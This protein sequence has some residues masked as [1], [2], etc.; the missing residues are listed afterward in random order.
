[1]PT[2][3]PEWMPVK[4]AATHAGLSERTLWRLIRSGAVVT[5]LSDGTPKKRLVRCDSLPSDSVNGSD[6][7]GALAHTDTRPANRA[8]KPVTLSD[9]T[10]LATVLADVGAAN[11]AMREELA[12]LRENAERQASE[13]AAIRREA[14]EREERLLSEL[15]AVR[16]ALAPSPAPV[17]ATPQPAPARPWWMFWR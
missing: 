1:M 14:A 7:A 13:L 15:A 9:V 12:A 5:R 8:K 2:E 16:A 4:D 3:Q 11:R 17:E 6:V 10:A